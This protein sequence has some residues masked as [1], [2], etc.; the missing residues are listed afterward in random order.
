MLFYINIVKFGINGTGVAAT[1]IVI[2]T[3]ADKIA[4]STPFDLFMLN[5]P[6]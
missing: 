4:K 3:T 6:Y 2:K 1:P 5:R